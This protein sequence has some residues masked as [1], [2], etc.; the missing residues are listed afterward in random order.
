MSTPVSYNGLMDSKPKPRSHPWSLWAFLVLV[1]I[2]VLGGAWWT[3][4]LVH[5]TQLPE[6]AVM[7]GEPNTDK[8]CAPQPIPTDGIEASDPL[9]GEM[10]ELGEPRIRTV[11]DPADELVNPVGS[12]EAADL[13]HEDY[14]LTDKD[15]VPK[16][17]RAGYLLA[18]ASP[19]AEL[20]PTFDLETGPLIHLPLLRG[21]ARFKE[22]MRK[23][24]PQQ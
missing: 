8:A 19:S 12:S 23:H 7:K 5:P 16:A 2:S 13:R 18:P 6:Q 14:R 21:E 10:D 4:R 20:L 3:Y 1:A 15:Y 24:S 22:L 11:V 17:I 9:I